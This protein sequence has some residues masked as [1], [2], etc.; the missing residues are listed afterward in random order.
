MNHLTHRIYFVI[1]CLAVSYS[2]VPGQDL[3]DGTPPLVQDQIQSLLEDLDE[4]SDFDFNTYTEF[5]T[6]RL[7][8]PLNINHA[9]REELK[10]L[11]F[12]SDIQINALI[13]YRTNLG[14]LLDLYELQA[15]PS[16]DLP[17]IRQA[18]PYF[19][20][21]KKSTEAPR[22]LDMLRKG[23]NETYLRW[24]LIPEKKKGFKSRESSG[25]AYAGSSDKIYARYRHR[26]YQDLSYGLTM[27][28]DPGESFFRGEN[29]QGFDFYSYHLYVKD[30][31]P[32]LTTLTIGDFSASMGQGLIMHSGFGRGKGSFVT[33]IKKGGKMLRPYTS[34]NEYNFLRGVGA[35][36][37]YNPIQITFFGSSKKIDANIIESQDDTEVHFSSIQQ[38]GLHRTK[39]EEQDKKSIRQNTAGVSVSYERNKLSLSINALHNHFSGFFQR[40]PRLYNKFYFQGS[41]LNNVSIDYDYS[42]RNLLLFGELATSSNQGLAVIQGL[43]TS[44]SSKI[45]LAV[46]YRNINRKYQTILGN[47]FTET[48]TVNNEQ[49][50]Y[51]G[52]DIRLNHN[53][54]LSTY[55]D[56]WHHPW[57]RFSANAPSTGSEYFIRLS[58]HVKRKTSAYIQIRNEQKGI[59]TSDDNRPVSTIQSRTRSNIRF[60]FN[61]KINAFIEWRNRI[62]FSN[63]EHFKETSR[64][65]L[66]Y[67]DL[68]F[69][70]LNTPYSFSTRL[71]YFSTDDYQSRIYAY[72]NDLLYQFSIPAFYGQGLRYYFNYRHRLK[73]ITVELRWSQT[74]YRNQST[75][76]S[77]NEEIEGNKRS[78]LK[79]QIR[80]LLD[81]Q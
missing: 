57:V 20:I 34:V 7:S 40:T 60:Q 67:Q 38:S 58:Y 79:L 46:L 10:E 6:N 11:L 14:N 5:L 78:E 9:S 49:G 39:S 21:N 30:M 29:P 18:L 62:E 32:R 13:T 15:V 45:D 16:W 61:H 8:N 43:M 65:I 51:I 47:A 2:L 56:I 1:C 12:L 71:A 54:K 73:N 28:K 27:E 31:H 17:T 55:Y 52:T 81:Q 72:E 33:N 76:S 36:L 68:L 19:T 80:Y 35:Q 64:G 66:L 24:S 50:I 25:P 41:T 3:M 23:R 74:I 69:R 37:D 70:K 59:N 53:W 44:L 75:I 4:E 63:V 42:L 26:Y 48:S 77:G 22:L